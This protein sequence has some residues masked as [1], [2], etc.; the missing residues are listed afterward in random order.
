MSV[1]CGRRRDVVSRPWGW[2]SS[3]HRQG[4]FSWTW[5]EGSC[6]R[7]RHFRSVDTRHW[8]PRKHACQSAHRLHQVASQSPPHYNNNVS[9]YKCSPTRKHSA[10]L[11]WPKSSLMGI[12]FT[13][14]ICSLIT[15]YGLARHHQC[16]RHGSYRSFAWIRSQGSGGR[17]WSWRCCRMGRRCRRAVVLIST[18]C[19]RIFMSRFF[20]MPRSTTWSFM[21]FCPYHSHTE[22]SPLKF[23]PYG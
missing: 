18:A 16:T 13:L 8:T 21:L 12:V 17:V 10:C 15:L 23:S 5:H 22:P 11:W 4:L 3:W 20:I 7:L 6:C 1:I 9:R 14:N 19:I 2:A